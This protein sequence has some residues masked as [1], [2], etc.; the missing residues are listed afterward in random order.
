MAPRD[1]G[2]ILDVDGLR[3]ISKHAVQRRYPAKALVIQEGDRPESLFIVM[4]GRLKAFV[5]DGAGREMILSIIEAGEYFGEIALD[6]GPRS[7]S[8]MSLEPCLLSVVPL[9]DLDGFIRENPAF[10]S[11][12]IHGLLGRIRSL[13][14]N[15]GSLALMDAYGRVARHL[16]ENAVTRDGIRFVPQRLTH[17]DIAS[18]V[19]CTREMVSRIFR[20]LVRGRFVSVEDERIVIHRSPV[21]PE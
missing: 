17:A 5:S 20:D 12:F 2:S 1:P 18:R 13:T 7:A 19:G 14:K 21:E 16:L 8:V 11:H 6:D 9:D 10:A 15:V 3:E 4:E